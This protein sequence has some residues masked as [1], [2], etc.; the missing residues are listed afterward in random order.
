MFQKLARLDMAESWSRHVPLRVAQVA[1][2]LACMATALIVRL[3][4]D[5]AAPTAGPY[6]LI[7][8]AVLI[9][10]L[11]GRW[12]AGAV[13]YVL[14]FMWS[15]WFILPHVGAGHDLA[16][17]EVSRLVINCATVLVILVFAEIFRSAVRTALAERDDA[18]SEV[19][20]REAHLH[21]LNESL[22]RKVAERA[23]ELGQTW[24]LSPD[25]L[26]VLNRNGFFEK[27]N[28]AWQATLGWSEDKIRT[29]PFVE[30][31]HPDDLERTYAA[32]EDINQGNPI[33]RF[34]N[35]YRHANG[36]WRWLSWVVVPEDGKFYG[37]ARDIT[38]EK[39]AHS[40]LAAT[41]EAL[42]QAQKMEAIGL[43]TGGVAHD[44]NNLLTVI[45]G[46]VDMLRRDELSDARRHRYVD[47]IGDTAD[48]AAKLTG[49]LLAFA[50]RQALRPEVFEVG[51]SLDGVLTM[52]RSLTGARIV[53]EPKLAETPC[54][55]RADRSQFDTA[56]VNIA[57]NA[58]D[59]MDG[60]GRIGIEVVGVTGIPAVRGHPPV[61]G[62][63]VAVSICDS[64][65]GISPENLARVFEPFFTTKPVGSGTGLG[66]SQVIGFAKQ[67]EGEVR[68]ESQVGVGTTFTL[69]LPRVLASANAE[70]SPEAADTD[71]SGEGIC[72]LLVEDNPQVGEFATHA[73]KELGFDSILAVDAVQALAKL[74]EHCGRFHIV[75][76]DVVMPGMSGLELADEIGRLYPDVPVVLTSGYS[77]VL[78]QDGGRAVRLLQKPYSID[79]LSLALRGA[80]RRER[81]RN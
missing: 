9:A 51:E 17:R 75:F 71:V 3:T 79:Q 5:L 41:Q 49:Q 28:P 46:S 68:I 55:V 76:S 8:P 52:V 50:R 27:T 14:G 4:I 80:L 18:L 65:Q 57:V 23:G 78:A 43:L 35:R 37:S 59:A 26:G 64:G 30:F 40:Q 36:D 62:D 77:H 34:E 13:T 53:L 63:F 22:E 44:F 16:P 73:L 15:W 69:Y 74:A 61:E 58:R 11:F 45:R 21:D 1:F 67:S 81:A 48:R 72:V 38:F 32:W 24:K 66:L 56:I 31:V 7:Y 10:T 29:T 12:P 20:Q 2:G 70:I 54:W 19:R 33:L 6:A 60:E 39:D 47:A 42:R 25:L